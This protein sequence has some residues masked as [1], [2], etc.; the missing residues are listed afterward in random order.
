MKCYLFDDQPTELEFFAEFVGKAWHLLRDMLVN[1]WDVDDPGD[2]E[3]LKQSDGAQ[4]E[5]EWTRLHQEYGLL[6]TDLMDT[7]DGE[8]PVE[9]CVLRGERLAEIARRGNENEPPLPMAIIAISRADQSPNV[10]TVR[11]S[12]ERV[13]KGDYP[14]RF[15]TW[16]IGYFNKDELTEN[17]ELDSFLVSFARMLLEIM[18]DA[19]VLD[20]RLKVARLTFDSANPRLAGLAEAEEVTQDQLIQLH[21]NELDARELALSMLQEGYWRYEPLCVVHEKDLYT[22]FEGNRRLAALKGLQDERIRARFH[23]KATDYELQRLERVECMVV[24]DRECSEYKRLKRF[25]NFKH[26]NSNLRWGTFARA[27]VINELMNQPGRDCS[28]DLLEQIAKQVGDTNGLAALLYR[29]YRVLKQA[30]EAEVFD[31]AQRENYPGALPF[32]QWVFGLERPGVKRFLGLEAVPMERKDPVPQSHLGALE[33]LCEWIHGNRFEGCPRL[34]GS[35]DEDWAR[36]AEVLENSEASSLL[37][38]QGNLDD[39]AH[40]LPP[41]TTRLNDALTFC[42][43][44]LTEAEKLL[45]QVIRGTAFQETMGSQL[46]ELATRCKTLAKSLARKKQAPSVAE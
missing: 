36:L 31:P 32:A 3:I 19:G 24:P 22:V 26:I 13:A 46:A 25:I 40:V 21:W 1:N 14:G 42:H 44:Q 43:N 4:A 29:A 23:V 33:E 45:P 10:G 27:S 28:K 41:L 39:A 2:L 5:L 9:Q 8:L 16:G 7:F 6:V 35:N 17:L 37:R 30:E 12:F 15:R 11:R 38:A 34:V 20:T 18:V